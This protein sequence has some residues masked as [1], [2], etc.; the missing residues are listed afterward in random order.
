MAIIRDPHLKQMNKHAAARRSKPSRILASLALKPGA[1]VADLGA[2]GGYYSYAFARAVEPK[3]KV[4][5]VDTSNDRLAYIQQQAQKE[6]FHNITTFQTK[7][8]QLKLPKT[9]FDLIFTRNM[10]HH[11]DDPK[12]YFKTISQ[13]LKSTGRVAIIDYKP[14]SHFRLRFFARRHHYTNPKLIV[15]TMSTVGLVL[16]TS[17]NFLSDQ[18]LQIFTLNSR[19]A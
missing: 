15:N 13:Y 1:I 10:F 12:V 19:G 8:N 17:Y 9:K 4:I 14:P 2:G 3:G 18:S 16:T 7:S 5:A 6:Q 11:L